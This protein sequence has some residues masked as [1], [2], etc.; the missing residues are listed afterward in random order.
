MTEQ[1]HQAS[2][3]GVNKYQL[4]PHC[5]TYAENLVIIAVCDGAS[6]VGQ[7]GNEAA[8]R[9][10]KT[11]P[12]L[13][14]M[15]CLSAVA[16][17]SKTHVDIFRKAKAVIAINGCQLACVSNVLKQ[18]EITP[19]Y[20]VVVAKEGISKRPS[21]DFTDEEVSRIASK[22]VKEFLSKYFEQ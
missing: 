20:E 11:F 21:L 17:G 7:V 19:T 1:I 4:L 14:R 6:T 13:V 5:A 9:L 12:N 15:C 2:G 22:V 16:A 8:R 18:K 3:S 10:T